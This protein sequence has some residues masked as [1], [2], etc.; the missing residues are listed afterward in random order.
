MD[1]LAAS[2][3]AREASGDFVFDHLLNTP[4]QEQIIFDNTFVT[5]WELERY[6]ERAEPHG[7]L[8]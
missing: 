4:R 5:D 3:V 7:T 1:E 8:A 6:F 2:T